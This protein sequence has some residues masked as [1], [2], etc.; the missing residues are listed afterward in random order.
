MSIFC[1]SCVVNPDKSV[2]SDLPTSFRDNTVILALRMH[3]RCAP[4][5]RIMPALALRTPTDENFIFLIGKG[6]LQCSIAYPDLHQIKRND[7]HQSAISGEHPLKTSGLKRSVDETS[8]RPRREGRHRKVRKKEGI[9]K[10][11]NTIRTSL[12]QGGTTRTGDNKSKN[13]T[14]YKRVQ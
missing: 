9:D 13:N 8:R 5:P 7:T 1:F 6:I 14:Q 3:C 4:H 2:L 12:V 10:E 11:I